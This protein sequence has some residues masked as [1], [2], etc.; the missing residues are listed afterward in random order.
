MQKEILGGEDSVDKEKFVSELWSS[1]F[2]DILNK[3]KVRILGT[4]LLSISF[5]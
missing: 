5:I 2:K 4:R 1:K 3:T